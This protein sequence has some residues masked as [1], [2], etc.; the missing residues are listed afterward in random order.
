M[1]QGKPTLPFTRFV[2]T[3]EYKTDGILQSLW[4]TWQLAKFGV[5]LLPGYSS[6]VEVSQSAQSAQ[7]L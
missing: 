1:V 5:F 6:D 4:R 2:Q 3:T 7:E